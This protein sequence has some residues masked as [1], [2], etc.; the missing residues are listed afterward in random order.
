MRRDSIVQLLVDKGAPLEIPNVY[1]ETPLYLSE[2]VIQYAG[3]GR[4]EIAPTPTSALLRKLG[5]RPTKPAYTL[6]PHYWPN[7]PHV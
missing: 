7:I 6:R 5:A 3:G 4:T 1:G 2:L